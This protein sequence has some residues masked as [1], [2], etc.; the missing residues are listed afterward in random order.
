M[1]PKSETAP[2]APTRRQTSQVDD[3]RDATSRRRASVHEPAPVRAARA[4]A[5]ARSEQH[6]RRPTRMRSGSDDSRVCAASN[7]HRLLAA[8]SRCRRRAARERRSA[9]LRRAARRLGAV[10]SA[11]LRR[12]AASVRRAPSNRRACA[13]SSRDARCTDGSIAP[14]NGR[15]KRPSDEDADDERREHDE[16]ARRAGRAGCRFFGLSSGPK[17]TFWNMHS[18]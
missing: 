3:E 12:G 2:T 17:N 16:L 11:G 6:A 9:R 13:A 4:N 7:V 14:R 10:G 15:G 18:R 1:P 8:P 5:S